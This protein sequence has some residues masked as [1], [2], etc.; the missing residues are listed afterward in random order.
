M[1]PNPGSDDWPASALRRSMRIRMDTPGGCRWAGS[2]STRGREDPRPRHLPAAHAESTRSGLAPRALPCLD[3]MRSTPITTVCVRLAGGD[4][5]PAILAG[6]HTVSPD[7]PPVAILPGRT[8]L[9]HYRLVE[10]IGAGGM[11]IV[12]RAVDTG[13]GRPVA[14]KVIGHVSDPDRRQRFVK[15]ARAAATFNHPNI[16]TIYEVGVDDGIDFI[17]ME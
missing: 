13:L 16:V 4:G 1:R 10:R 14:L 7:T 2:F 8:E 3:I 15:E 11:G 6:V 17:V 5:S 12:Y 9:S